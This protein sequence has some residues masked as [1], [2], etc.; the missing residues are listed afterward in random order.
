MIESII[1]NATLPTFQGSFENELK[2]QTETE[3]R[4]KKELEKQEV[5]PLELTPTPPEQ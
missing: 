4:I 5:K 2:R 3:E 1:I